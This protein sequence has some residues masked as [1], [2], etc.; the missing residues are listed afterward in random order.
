MTCE[1]YWQEGVLLVEQGQRDPHRDGCVDCRRA[2]AAREEIVRALPGLGASRAG[3]PGWQL[4]VWSRI[5]RNEAQRAR[6]SY[7]IGGGL[8]T[9]CA[10]AAV[11]LL[12]FRGP[13][14][15][16][17]VGPGGSAGAVLAA[18]GDRPRPQIEIVSGP[19]AMRALSTSARVGDWIRVSVAAGGEV[20]IYRANRLVLRCPAQQARPG[21]TPD[22]LGLVAVA[23][24]ATAGDY[25]LV[26]IPGQTAEPVGAGALD[27]D[28]AAVV[29]AGGDYK[30][31]ELQVR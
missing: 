24:L 15:A 22:T 21:C 14:P 28:L 23:E 2:H 8:A 1:R 6:R 5:A 16:Q 20:R 3:D 13:T 27:K 30:V 11:W 4:K 17:L 25:Q 18:T 10:A 29:N 31:I 12:L 9:V 19:L 26:M 7:W